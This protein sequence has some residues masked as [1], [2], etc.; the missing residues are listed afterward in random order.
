MKQTKHP[1][2]YFHKKDVRFIVRLTGLVIATSLIFI[3]SAPQDIKAVQSSRFP[4]G[5]HATIAYAEPG[6]DTV[7]TCKLT[8][9]GGG[10]PLPPKPPFPPVNVVTCPLTITGGGIPLPPKP[11]F[12]GVTITTPKLTITGITQ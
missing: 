9:T 6:P 7:V 2:H 12:P 3:V 5:L 11:P 1:E 8:V 10:I 4:L